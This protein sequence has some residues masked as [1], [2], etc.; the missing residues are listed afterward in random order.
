MSVRAAALA[1]AIV[2]AVAGCGRPTAGTCDSVSDCTR[3]GPCELAEGPACV[4]GL[5]RYP[6]KR[7][8]APPAPECIDGDSTYRTYAS[9]GTCQRDGS[10]SYVTTDTPCAGC[11]SNCLGT[12]IGFSCTDLQSG[13]RVAGECA[14]GNPPTC[15][16]TAA[17]D[18]QGCDDGD[19]CTETDACASGV[20]GGARIADGQPCSGRAGACV[21]GL[22]IDCL[23]ASHC[24]DGNP[25]TGD[26]CAATHCKHDPVAD[27]TSCGAGGA[28]CEAGACKGNCVIGGP[29]YAAGAK[30]P[31]NPCQLCNPGTN[32]TAWSNAANYT[33][34]SSGGGA[35]CENGTCKAIC[36]IGGAA[37][38]PGVDPNNE[39]QRCDPSVAPLAWTARTGQQCGPTSSVRVA[40]TDDRWW[41]TFD[42]EC[43][44]AWAAYE[45]NVLGILDTQD[46]TDSYSIGIRFRSLPANLAGH[47][48]LHG[49][50]YLYQRGS[51]YVANVWAQRIT[52]DWWES[53][54]HIP[55]V[56]STKTGATSFDS[57]VGWHTVDIGTYVDGWLNSAYPNYGVQLSDDYPFSNSVSEASKSFT[58]RRGPQ[59]QQPYLE[60]QFEPWTCSASAVCQR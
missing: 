19:P 44:P 15:S 12:C 8:D 47:A 9:L 31:S 34:C 23:N 11:S 22:C 42:G 41:D 6:A 33:A 52:Q 40:D 53:T 21:S 39:C 18:A 14:P 49:Y 3:P 17:P 60:I 48:I 54:T 51:D 58:S 29:T 24:D 59:E 46:D 35:L 4:E 26:S 43:P 38:A 30:N 16:Y 20:C 27:G 5:C 32:A 7:C 28:V 37:R 57:S 1:G 2:V 45:F 25:C 50:L 13:C 10:C 36:Y 55:T 56:D